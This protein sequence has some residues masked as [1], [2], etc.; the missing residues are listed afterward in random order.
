MRSINGLKCQV[1][2]V[3]VNMEFYSLPN[4]DY[5]TDTVKKIRKTIEV[6]IEAN[7]NFTVVLKTVGGI[8]KKFFDSFDFGS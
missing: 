3:P 7:H 1:N 5:D 6:D 2:L 8:D 4:P